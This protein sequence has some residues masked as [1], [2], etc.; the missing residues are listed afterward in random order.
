MAQEERYS[1]EKI[2]ALKERWT[3]ERVDRVVAALRAR[4]NWTEELDGLP[5]VEEIRPLEQGRQAWL[6]L[7]H[8]ERLGRDLRGIPLSWADLGPA[9][10]QGVDLRYAFLEHA[11]LK[12]AVLRDARLM[13]ATLDRS[14]L[15][16][17]DLRDADLTEARLE[18]ALMDFA[19]LGRACL[20]KAHLDNARLIGAKLHHADLFEAQMCNCNICHAELQ[21]ADLEAADLRSVS[22][23]FAEFH[24][25]NLEGADLSTAKVL[26]TDFRSC[27]VDH[28][29]RIG[30][31]RFG[32]RLKIADEVAY[33]RS[34]LKELLNLTR[35]EK[36][37][38]ICQKPQREQLCQ[39][40][41]NLVWSPWLHHLIDAYESIYGIFSTV[42]PSY[43]IAD[44]YYYSLRVVERRTL[45]WRRRLWEY[46]YDLAC[47]Y[48]VR[49][50]RMFGVMAVV[51][52]VFAGVYCWLGNRDAL[53]YGDAVAGGVSFW[54]G[55][56]ISIRTFTT[57]GLG[58]W[59][60]ARESALAN[61]S[62]LLEAL[63]GLFLMGATLALFV[64]R[65]GKIRGTRY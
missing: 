61:F 32:R 16:Y 6:R 8:R 21:H 14:D 15:R 20:E 13:R 11:D 58:F 27:R 41:R 3:R 53:L 19:N 25:T 59:E 1:P 45:P 17:A 12:N 46:V 26:C 48:G 42:G 24:D 34:V 47:G 50:F 57:L 43:R 39:M 35:P 63:L 29:T 37:S 44:E 22:A 36:L 28:G 5:F 52:A 60:P 10:G 40:V 18:G 9:G 54:T 62:V 33:R 65:M 49:P 4:G 23:A 64:R 2:Q 31:K 55:L 51:M 56:I 7:R 30:I 38:Q